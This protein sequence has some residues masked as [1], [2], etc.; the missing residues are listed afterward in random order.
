MSSDILYISLHRLCIMYTCNNFVSTIHLL[1]AAPVE[2]KGISNL[3]YQRR[4]SPLR[5]SVYFS[6]YL[7][8]AVALVGEINLSRHWPGR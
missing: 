4:T 5:A 2:L 7:S 6:L 8:I 1:T 3:L